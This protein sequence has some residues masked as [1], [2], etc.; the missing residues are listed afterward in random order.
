MRTARVN[1][2]SL[3]SQ[4]REDRS[5]VQEGAVGVKRMVKESPTV[6]GSVLVIDKNAASEIAIDGNIAVEF[7]FLC[8]NFSGS[9]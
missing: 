2:F 4:N 3:P 5:P 6:N 8:V 9:K 1:A 7:T